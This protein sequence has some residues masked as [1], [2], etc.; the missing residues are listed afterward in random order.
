MNNL[1]FKTIILTAALAC[2]GNALAGNFELGGLSASDIRGIQGEFK[3]APAARTFGDETIGVDAAVRIPFK[4]LKKIMGMVAEAD[5]QL[6][7]IDASAPILSRSGDALKLT[8]IR[9]NLN[10]IIVDPTVTLK[11]YFEGQDR[12]AIKIQ[13]VQ[14]HVSMA[15]TPGRTSAQTPIA[16]PVDGAESDFDKS[17]M[18]ASIVQVITDGISSSLAEALVAN[19]SPLKASEIINFKYDKKAWI[20]HTRISTSTIK[21]YLPDGFMGDLHM[22]G[23]A[24][25]ENSISIKFQT[26]E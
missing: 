8:N 14:V 18:M 11:P 26:A 25:S 12:L 4:V 10:G 7:I 1:T 23:L 20:L 13:R 2:G 5:K 15:P 16:A 6:T 3:S 24:L 19:A 17:E 22:T 9:V 21:R